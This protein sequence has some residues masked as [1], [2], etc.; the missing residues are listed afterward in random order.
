MGCEKCAENHKGDKYIKCECECH[1]VRYWGAQIKY[2]A[3]LKQH[4]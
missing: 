4:E 3:S 2:R 1:K